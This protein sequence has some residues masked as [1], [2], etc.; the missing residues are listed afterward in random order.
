MIAEIFAGAF[1]DKD[2]NLE[3]EFATR[4]NQLEPMSSRHRPTEVLRPE[5]SVHSPNKLKNSS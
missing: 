3:M 5:W 2:V 4:L 1:M